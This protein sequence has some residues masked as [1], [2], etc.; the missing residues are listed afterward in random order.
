MD[1]SKSHCENVPIAKSFTLVIRNQGEKDT[2]SGNTVA[3]RDVTLS[4]DG[5]THKA[6]MTG[7]LPHGKRSENK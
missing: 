3:E 1:G 2:K 6:K 4:A 7:N 5:K